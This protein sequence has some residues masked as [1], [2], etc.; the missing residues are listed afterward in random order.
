LYIAGEVFSET[1][2]SPIYND[3]F[4]TN[5]IE[6]DMFMIL[7][8]MV[9]P[10]N[11]KAVKHLVGDED[12]KQLCIRQK[13]SEIMGDKN[14]MPIDWFKLYNA[15]PTKVQKLPENIMEILKSTCPFSEDKQV[16]DTHILLYIPKDVSRIG[17]SGS[18][19]SEQKELTLH[20]YVHGLTDDANTVY[21]SECHYMF[22]SYTQDFGY[23][24]LNDPFAYRLT[25][26]RSDDSEDS[27]YDENGY[28]ENSYYDAYG[29]SKEESKWHRRN[30]EGWFLVY[31]GPLTEDGVLTESRNKS[32]I[33]QKEFLDDINNKVELL[34]KENNLKVSENEKTNKLYSTSTPLTTVL[35]VKSTYNKSG[36]LKLKYCYAVTEDTW[37]RCN[38]RVMVGRIGS[39]APHTYQF[40]KHT[41]DSTT[42]IM[43]QRTL[44]NTKTVSESE[45]DYK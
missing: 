43:I 21:N 18:D 44:C 15:I 9:D 13:V 35:N 2:L 14:M 27:D 25:E 4:G 28:S 23:C 3:V 37:K 45:D 26:H 42:G 34:V 20:E 33:D 22:P 32:L 19:D 24:E 10:K 29:Y 7:L 6:K 30:E 31:D 36:D 8:G 16:K 1:E 5:N 17:L 38:R 40:E 11:N 41:Y 39:S 12:Y